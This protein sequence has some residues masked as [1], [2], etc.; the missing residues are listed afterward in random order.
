MIEECVDDIGHRARLFPHGIVAK[1]LEYLH[2]GGRQRFWRRLRRSSSTKMG[3]LLPHISRVGALSRGS[4]LVQ[5]GERQALIEHREPHTQRN[6]GGI[7]RWRR[8]KSSSTGVGELHQ[9]IM[10][11]ESGSIGSLSLRICAA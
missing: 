11:G 5:V 8:M 10:N 3:S 2:A 1:A 4:V 7:L 9:A 6:G